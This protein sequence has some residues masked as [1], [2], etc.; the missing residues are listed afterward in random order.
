MWRQHL[1]AMKGAPQLSF[2]KSANVQAPQHVPTTQLGWR[3]HFQDMSADKMADSR[4][5]H[6]LAAHVG[7][8]V[9]SVLT[10]NPEHQQQIAGAVAG[11]MSG[12]T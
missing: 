11:M 10:D 9:A 3:D 12:S 8:S 5:V 2:G 7:N 4:G 6:P 1:Q